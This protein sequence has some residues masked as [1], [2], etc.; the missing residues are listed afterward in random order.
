MLSTGLSHP[1]AEKAEGSCLNLAVPFELS[2]RERLDRRKKT[3]ANVCLC[4]GH[5]WK[6]STSP[7]MSCGLRSHSVRGSSSL[8]H[9]RR[10]QAGCD[11]VRAEC[12][13]PRPKCDQ[14]SVHFISRPHRC[15]LSVHLW[16]LPPLRPLWLCCARARFWQVAGGHGR[17]GSSRSGLV[18]AVCLP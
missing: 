14:T 6:Y 4:R 1:R 13:Y 5:G 8:C 7:G 9:R 10:K 3:G 16:L 15:L 18:P 11:S 17:A 12:C 2:A